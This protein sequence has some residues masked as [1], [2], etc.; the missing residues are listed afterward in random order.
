MA[1]HK[2]NSY[3]IFSICLSALYLGQ[4]FWIV[5]EVWRIQVWKAKA[6]KAKAAAGEWDISC[7]PPCSCLL[8]VCACVISWLNP[9]FKHNERGFKSLCCCLNIKQLLSHALPSSSSSMFVGAC[10]KLPLS[11]PVFVVI[12]WFYDVQSERLQNV[13]SKIGLQLR[14]K[15]SVFPGSAGYRSPAAGWTGPAQWLWDRGEE[16]QTGAT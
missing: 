15:A 7:Y 16:I 14:V 11:L 10:L 3:H 6:K 8:S 5:W 4:I 12:L 1:T 2:N 13:C 9:V